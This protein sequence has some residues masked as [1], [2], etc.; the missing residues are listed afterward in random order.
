MVRDTE[1]K[2]ESVPINHLQEIEYSESCGHVTD[3]VT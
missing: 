3:D 1:F 2:S